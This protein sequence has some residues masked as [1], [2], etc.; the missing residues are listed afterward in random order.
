VKQATA[1]GDGSFYIGAEFDK[2]EAVWKW[3]V[4]PDEST[5]FWN[6]ESVTNGQRVTYTMRIY[7]Q[8]LRNPL[9]DQLS[10]QR[11]RPTVAHIVHFAANP[12][13]IFHVAAKF[14]LY[15]RDEQLSL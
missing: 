1:T 10:F 6:I 12:R 13:P 9:H 4:G 8:C 11:P 15:P 3:E 2:G 7:C 5:T 14:S